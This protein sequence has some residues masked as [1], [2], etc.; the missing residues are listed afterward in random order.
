MAEKKFAEGIWFNEPTDK[1]P[2]WVVG[3]IAI[4]PD[5]FTDWLR[6]QDVDSKGYVKLKVNR[7]KEGKPYVELDDYRPPQRNEQP[8]RRRF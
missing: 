3:N 2:D 5:Q 7:S 8:Q 6:Q 4:R 1:A